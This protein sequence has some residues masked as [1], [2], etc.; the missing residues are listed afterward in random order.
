MSELKSK[1]KS[2][3]NGDTGYQF[4][5][6]N[7][8]AEQYEPSVV[9]EADL[10]RK[11]DLRPFMTPVENQ[12]S[13][14]S[15]TAN[16]IAGA[17]EYLIKRHLQ[18]A[19]VDIS[20]LFIYY[21]ARWR[22]GNQNKVT[23]SRIQY[24]MESLQTFGACTEKSWPYNVKAVLEKPEDAAY[25]EASRF[26]VLQ[27]QNLPTQLDKWKSCLAEGYPIVFGCAL[28][29]SFDDCKKQGGVVPMPAPSDA[30]RG[31]H[32]L[33]AMLCVGYSD[34][35]EAFIVRNSWGDSWGERGYCYIPYNYLMSEKLNLG[36]SWIIRAAENIPTPEEGWDDN[37]K[38]LI[39]N[40]PDFNIN[41][42][43]F[44][45][46]DLINLVFFN[47]S[48]D[49]DYSEYV[50]DEYTTFSETIEYVSEYVEESEEFYSY[51]SSSEEYEE[52][53]E[54]EDEES[55]D[56]E[57]EEEDEEE[58][59]DESNEEDEEETDDESDEEDEEEADEESDEED[60]EEADDESD[61]ED[62]E[63]A[64]DESDEEDEEEADDESDDESDEEDEEEADDESDEEDEEEADDESD[65]SDES[66]E[67]EEEEEEDSGDDDGGDDSDDE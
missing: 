59:N 67:G 8:A 14:G 53:E 49:V 32:R 56:E 2:G 3:T 54:E 27:M 47:L 48:D 22:A 33:H 21:N 35:D 18:G 16:A 64:D 43:S 34:V 12:G 19:E 40:K 20:R 42:Y 36:D 28:F 31:E 41:Q 11:V 58:A 13:I 17:Y 37:N 30:G 7:P 25:S 10:P 62:E 63:E 50:P 57:S 9:S 38:S 65:E 29:D 4:M 45:A 1:G 66:D 55:D 15:C 26:K 60:E 46:Y 24:G 61:E 52:E 39:K 51:E 6:A 5:N 23:G 44:D